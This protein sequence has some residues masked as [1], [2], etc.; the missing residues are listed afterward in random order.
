MTA[1]MAAFA[2]ITG[3]E[4]DYIMQAGED[5]GSTAIGFASGQPVGTF[6]ILAPSDFK[7]A[8]IVQL[9][10]VVAFNRLLVSMDDDTLPDAFFER[11]T[12]DGFGTFKTADAD[13]ITR[14]GGNTNWTWDGFGLFVNGQQFNIVI[15]G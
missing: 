7:T 4:V 2:N 9:L 8:K 10:T 15:F 5:S 6:G 1:M 3:T 14:T 11:I 13:S 12:V